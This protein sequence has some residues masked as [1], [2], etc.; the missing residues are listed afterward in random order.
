MRERPLWE[1]SFAE[2]SPLAFYGGVGLLAG[3]F[4]LG[5]APAWLWVLLYPW[6]RLRL[7]WRVSL[8]PGRLVLRPP[9]GPARTVPWARV[10]GV[11]VGLW[12]GG[13]LARARRA[14][15]LLL[16]DGENLPL[17]LPEPEAWGERF[18]EL[19]KGRTS[20]SGSPDG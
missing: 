14:L 16:E 9:L 18:R 12:P 2:L 20:G 8:Y 6:W 10:V 15:F 4:A 3:A 17:P 5:E 13:P 11:E 19:L 7:G 1:A